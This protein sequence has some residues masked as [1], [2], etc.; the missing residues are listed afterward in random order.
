M[1]MCENDQIV[2]IINPR[3]EE[4]KT[5]RKILTSVLSFSYFLCECSRFIFCSVNFDVVQELFEYLV[6]V[7]L[8]Y[9]YL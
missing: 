2:Y 7:F 1:I 5:D 9:R 4:K 8:E 3:H 6:A